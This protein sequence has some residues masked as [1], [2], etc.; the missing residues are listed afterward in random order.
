LER[1]T[2]DDG[3]EIGTGFILTGTM[4]VDKLLDK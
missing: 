3:D 2:D 4:I 1:R